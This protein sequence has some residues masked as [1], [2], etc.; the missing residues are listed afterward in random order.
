MRLEAAEACSGIGVSGCQE[1]S[2]CRGIGAGTNRS[3][4]STSRSPIPL[5]S[6]LS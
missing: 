1:V 2:G 3:R 6:E 4:T 5:T